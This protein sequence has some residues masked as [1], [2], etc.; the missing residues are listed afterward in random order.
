MWPW[1]V[2]SGEDWGSQSALRPE[3][4]EKCLLPRRMKSHPASFL[5]IVAAQGGSVSP[6]HAPLGTPELP[7]GAS[8]KLGGVV[9]SDDCLRYLRWLRYLTRSSRP[10]HLPPVLAK[11]L[12]VLVDS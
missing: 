4:E 11:D 3:E 8:T 10:P 2:A 1:G 9:D 7:G 5:L 6:P 12:G